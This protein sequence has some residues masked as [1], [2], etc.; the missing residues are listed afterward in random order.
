MDLQ[1]K[2]LG[3]L[4]KN[5]DE[6][7]AAYNKKVV[8]TTKNEIIGVRMSV[9][10]EM[11]ER[12]KGKCEQILNLPYST[13][14]ELMLKGLVVA[15][16]E[17]T[18]D[19]KKPYILQFLELVDNWAVV[20]SFCSAFVYNES[21][22]SYFIALCKELAFSEK[23]YISRAGIVLLFTKLHDKVAINMAYKLYDRLTYGQH[24]KD[25]AVAWG[26]AVYSYYDES[27][28]LEYF[29]NTD[30]PIGVKLK[31]AHKVRESSRLSDDY[32]AKVTFLVNYERA[33]RAK[34]KKEQEGKEEDRD[35]IS[36]KI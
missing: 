25:T 11:A 1:K 14:E 7:I 4:K 16:A 23:E 27:R 17:G 22:R 10:Q 3:E 30:I 8:N 19:E 20:D 18:I 28:S 9:I 24:Y 26:M 34:R 21:Q 5:K 32:K 12:Y 35:A 33:W 13:Y 6:K 36:A 2:I 31:A 29:I 15:K